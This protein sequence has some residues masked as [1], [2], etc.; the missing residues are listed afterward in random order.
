MAARRFRWLQSQLGALEP[1]ASLLAG[2]A[3]RGK[4]TRAS[5]KTADYPGR[6]FTM[7]ATATGAP[8]IPSGFPP[9]TAPETR[10][11]QQIDQSAIVNG[12]SKG[13]APLDCMVN[14]LVAKSISRRFMSS[15]ASFLQGATVVNATGETRAGESL[16]ADGRVLALYFAVRLSLPVSC[17]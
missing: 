17:V 14:T 16:G 15:S 5:E 6:R 10:A 4:P 2:F 9:I 3:R 1:G 8:D 12:Q 7:L 13:N 11:Q